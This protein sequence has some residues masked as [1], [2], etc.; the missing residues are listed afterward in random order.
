MYRLLALWHWSL[1]GGGRQQPAARSPAWPFRM[2]WTPRSEATKDRDPP[3]GPKPWTPTTLG[4]MLCCPQSQQCP[5]AQAEG[6]WTKLHAPL[7]P[8]GG[9]R[10]LQPCPT[11]S[12]HDAV[13]A[14]GA[15]RSPAPCGGA[16]RAAAASFRCRA[17][18]RGR[19]RHRL[20]RG[21]IATG[22]GAGE[23]GG[24]SAFCPAR[25]DVPR[26]TPGTA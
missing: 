6:S 14:P 10:I 25:G 22:F 19:A 24:S 5:P 3:L 16:P 20:G 13:P 18:R 21:D 1:G 4:L 2:S 15:H 12:Q 11:P 23:E 9:Q 17:G 26:W 8:Q 7:L